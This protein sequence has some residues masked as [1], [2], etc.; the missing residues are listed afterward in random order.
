MAVVEAGHHGHGLPHAAE[1]LPRVHGL[2]LACQ[3]HHACAGGHL[4]VRQS[5]DRRG[6]RLVVPGRTPGH[7]PARRDGGDVRRRRAG[8]LAAE[9]CEAARRGSAEGP[10]DRGVRL[11]YFWRITSTRPRGPMNQEPTQLT[12]LTMSA[13]PTAVQKPAILKPGS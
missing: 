7:R 2:R 11:S 3:E 9:G 10:V 8:E 5:G 1:L 12:M 4:L 13:P 6:A